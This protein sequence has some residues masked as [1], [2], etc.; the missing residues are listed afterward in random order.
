MQDHHTFKDE[1]NIYDYIDNISFT[2]ITESAAL[3]SA[4][5]LHKIKMN[6]LSAIKNRFLRKKVLKQERDEILSEFT[7]RER[8]HF[9]E[10]KSLIKEYKQ[11][12]KRILA[13]IKHEGSVSELKEIVEK[14]KQHE[15]EML[16][17]I[18]PTGSEEVIEKLRKI[19]QKHK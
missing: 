17:E 9:S 8:N 3:K 11:K 15:K 19:V 2:Q 16:K 6:L 4:T 13:K 12:E 1:I 18:K 10:L 5:E 14:A 7:Q